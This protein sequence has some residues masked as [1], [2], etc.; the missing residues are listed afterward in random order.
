[1]L[2]ASGNASNLLDKARAYL[3][4]VAIGLPAM[5]GI[6]VLSAYMV[7]DGDNNRTVIATLIMTGVNI[8]LDLLVAFVIH[9]DTF[10]MGLTTSMGYYVSLFVLLL[11]FKKKDI[12]LKFNIKSIKWKESINVIKVCLPTGVCRISNT[13]RSALMNNMLAIV[14]SSSAIAAYTVHR[15]ADGFLNPITIG[16]ADT[17][18]LIAGILMGEQDRPK[19][20]KLLK[21]SVNATFIFTLGISIIV[22]FAAP[23]FASL[24]IK[25]DLEALAYAT[26][27]V[28]CYAIGMPL[29]GLNLIYLNYLQGIGKS[30]LSSITGLLLEGG[31]LVISAYV[32]LP[33]FNQEAIW[34]A[35]PVTQLL[36]HIIYGI[37]VFVYKRKYKIKSKGLW[38]RV[39]LLPDN[40]DVPEEDKIDK[41]I[42]S[43]D[44]V[45][46]LSKA[47]WDFCTEHGCSSKT[48]Y[49]ISLSVEE[50]AGNIVKHG[51]KDG[52]NHCVD[53]RVI[54]KGEN[55]I[56]RMRDNCLLFNPKKQLEL[57]S[58]E[59]ITRHIGLRMAFSMAKDV[60]Y[61]SIL[62]L[63]NLVIKI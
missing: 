50:L 14:A 58:D 45:L 33:I 39:L 31:L 4:G 30:T 57:F 25:D 51:F 26:R 43:K 32:M 16:M 52:K 48:R 62:K 15:S 10:E 61:T 8:L 9:G 56:V 41:T 59:D 63:N 6:R 38:N 17:V 1:M 55:Y 34:I 29:Y 13:I 23:L 5:N 12:L 22:F 53:L 20:K 40:F 11:H 46:D 42:N 18:A 36:M 49:V 19:M 47:A 21:T 54:K 37:I 3:I 2:G 7:L 60:Q 27:A 44:E 35:F 28:Q 24:Y